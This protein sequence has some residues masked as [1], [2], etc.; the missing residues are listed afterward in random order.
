MCAILFAM[1]AAGGG[2][3]RRSAISSPDLSARPR[4]GRN[5]ACRRW[6]C[7]GTSRRP[8][9]PHV[10]LIA[11]HRRN[12]HAARHL[13]IPTRDGSRLIKRLCTH[14]AHKLQ[15]QFDERQAHVPFDAETRLWLEAGAEALQARLAAPEIGR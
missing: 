14:W 2:V 11:R 12:R 6:A 1:D 8:I 3:A 9:R 7:T 4:R 10:S 5:V 13:L 15:V